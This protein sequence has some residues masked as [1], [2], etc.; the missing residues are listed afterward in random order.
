MAVVVTPNIG[1]TEPEVNV[2]TGW[3]GTLN[4]NFTIIDSIF[5]ANGSGASVGLNVG[6][7]KTLVIGGTA[8]IGSNDGTASAAAATMRGAAKTGT[9]AIGPNVTIQAGNGTGSGGSGSFIVQ[10]APAAAS[11]TTPNS[12][13]TALEVR[14]TGV[15]SAPL[16]LEVAG[17]N[18]SSLVMPAGSVTAYAGGVAPTGWLFCDGSGQLTATYPALFAAIGYTYGGGGASFNLPDLRGR[19]PAGR[20]NMGGNSAGRITNGGS[21]IVGTTLGAA[22]GQ[23]SVTLTINQ[24]PSHNHT[25]PWY[26]GSGGGGTGSGGGNSAGTTSS[27]GGGQAHTNTQ[28]TIILNYIIKT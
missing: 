21:G 22:G 13:R 3:G 28:P 1:L 4:A 18:I 17:Q 23:E 2:S 16:G 26:T 19:V 6:S 9:N 10:T 14:S 25:Y 20:D 15:V 11:S 27:V 12:M 7:G 24:I 5:A 8:I